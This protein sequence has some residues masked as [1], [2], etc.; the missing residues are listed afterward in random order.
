MVIS[1]INAKYINDYKIR[2]SFSDGIEK[3]IDF[4]NFLNN[5]KNGMAKKYLNLELFKNYTIEYG[6]IIWNDYEMCFPIW[7]LHEGKI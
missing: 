7:D 1:I 3:D 4:S 2:F 6:D 5:A